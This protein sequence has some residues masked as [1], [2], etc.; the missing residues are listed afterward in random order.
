MDFPNDKPARHS[1]FSQAISYIPRFHIPIH[2]L[3]RRCTLCISISLAAR[4]KGTPSPARVAPA[5]MHERDGQTVKN[6]GK[7]TMWS[8]TGTGTRDG[9]VFT[10]AVSR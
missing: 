1:A 3:R 6:M 8:G 4:V 2:F 9:P 7:Y 5:W 10:M